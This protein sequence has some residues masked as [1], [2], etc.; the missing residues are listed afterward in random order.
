VR[1]GNR[2]FFAAA[3][4][5]AVTYFAAWFI[6][7]LD[8]TGVTVASAVL[9]GTL[10]LLWPAARLVARKTDRELGE[11]REAVGRIAS[12]DLRPP[13]A[14]AAPSRSGPWVRRSTA[15]PVKCATA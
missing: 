6:L 2:F 15:W 9:G 8:A 13:R 4:V 14:R 7:R 10:L 12:G 3:A 5:L 11:A 1:L